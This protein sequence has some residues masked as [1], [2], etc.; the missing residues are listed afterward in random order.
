MRRR[1]RK[2]V[3]VEGREKAILGGFDLFHVDTLFFMSILSDR[4]F[5][6][7]DGDLILRIC[8]G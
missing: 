6:C 5:V 4:W 2:K 1:A 7:I 3:S 8:P